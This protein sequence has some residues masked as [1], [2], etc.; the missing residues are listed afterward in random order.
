MAGEGTHALFTFDT[1]HHALWAEEIAADHSVPTEVVPPPPAAGARC[2]IALLVL[3]ADA[4]RLSALLREAGVE[5]RRWV[6]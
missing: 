1:T 2:D 6:G 5:Y 3:E 4:E